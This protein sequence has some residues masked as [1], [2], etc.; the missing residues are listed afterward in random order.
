[1]E[2]KEAR[3]VVEQ[4]VRSFVGSVAAGRNHHRV[5]ARGTR[6]LASNC[7]LCGGLDRRK[8]PAAAAHRF[9]RAGALKREPAAG[10]LQPIRCG[11]RCKPVG[12]QVE[13]TA[14]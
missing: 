1:M 6:T 13:E 7:G 4:P 2:T 3:G 8:M 10:R 5:V 14:A 11:G 9:S 12:M